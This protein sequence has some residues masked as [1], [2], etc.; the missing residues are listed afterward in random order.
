[1]LEEKMQKAIE[2]VGQCDGTVVAL[3]AGVD[4]SVVA[5]FARKRLGDRAVATTALSESLPP[6]ELEIAKKTAQE[7]GIRHIVVRTNELENPD[8]VANEHDRCY[9]CK[10]TLY[11]ELRRVANDLG[12]ESILD[13]THVDDLGED[14]PGLKAAREAGVLSPL[15]Y[16]GFSKQDVRDAARILGL[17][18]WDKPAMPCLSSRIM[19]G[20]QVTPEKLSIIG[21]AEAFIK[22]LTGVRNLRVRYD[23]MEAR[24]EIAP[25]ERSLFFDGKVLDQVDHELRRL[26]FSRVVMDLKGYTR[27]PSEIRDAGLPLPMA[28]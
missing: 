13:G 25:E 27:K 22:N 28:K 26:G 5:F 21:Q 11:Q 23:A 9:Y 12:V 10:E 17:T 2:Y 8:Y 20:E 1:M 4:S 14:R 24:I 3:S 6:G 7:I 19:H 15:L 16:A 18:V